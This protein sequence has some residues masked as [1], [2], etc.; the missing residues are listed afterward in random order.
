MRNPG[1]LLACDADV[2]SLGM[3]GLPPPADPTWKQAWD[4]ALYGPAGFLRTQPASSSIPAD[5]VLA[6][7]TSTASNR[8]AEVALLGAAGPLAPTLSGLG[9]SVR[10]DVPP[11]FTGLVLAV[12][13]LSHVPAHVVQMDADGFPR[14]VHVSPSTGRETLG[15][16]LNETSV[17]Q[18]IGLWLEKWWPVVDFGADARAEVGTA[19]DTAWLGVVRRLGAGGVAVAVEPAHLLA[20]RPRLGS[21]TSPS[22]AVIP[23]G[24]RDLVASVA[25]DSVAAATGGR[26][27]SE[28]GLTYVESAAA[29]LV[30]G[31]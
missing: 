14:L 7:V 23:D 27:V 10:F 17:P 29:P 5:R 20:T 11:G 2:T 28:H 9:S 16:R 24:R 8:L 4:T 6:L 13:W 21:L 1:S 12:D 22:R 26:V 25:V 30:N 18:S 3:P 19:R 31:A 15:A